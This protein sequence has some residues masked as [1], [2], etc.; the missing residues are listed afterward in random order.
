MPPEFHRRSAESVILISFALSGLS[1]LLAQTVWQRELSRL[2]GA[3]TPASALVFG[4]VMGGLAAGSLLGNSFANRWG[5]KVRLFALLEALTAVI[6]F[7]YVLALS[8]GALYSSSSATGFLGD[9]IVRR[10][11]AFGLVLM[12]SIVMGA[13]WPVIV[14]AAPTMTSRLYA[15]NLGGAFLGAIGGAFFLV[16]NFGLIWTL[17]AAG[18]LNLAAALGAYVISP[19]FQVRASESIQ[20]AETPENGEGHSDILDVDLPFFDCLVVFVSAVVMLSLEVLWTRLFTLVLGSSVYSV[21][22]VLAGCL[23]GLYTGATIVS[24]LSAKAKFSQHLLISVLLASAVLIALQA[25]FLNDLPFIFLEVSKQLL[26]FNVGQFELFL[27]SRILITFACVFIP[28]AVLGMSF[29]LVLARNSEDDDK[30]RKI[31]WL[32]SLSAIGS[33]VGSLCTGLILL[34]AFGVRFQSG[35]QA[36]FISLSIF[37]LA[38]VLMVILPL[39]YRQNEKV[40]TINRP[41]PVAYLVIFV[42]IFHGMPKPDIYLL[43]SGLGFVSAKEMVDAKL[44]LRQFIE[45][46]RFRF[47]IKFYREG[48]NTTV[49]VCENLDGNLR[50]LKNDGKVEASIPIDLS[51]PAPGSDYFTQTLLADLPYLVSQ[52]DNLKALVIGAGTGTTYSALSENLVGGKVTVA[53]IESYVLQAGKKFKNVNNEQNPAVEKLVCDARSHL[54]YDGIT[55]NLIVSQPAEPWVN[56]ASDL[57][58]KEFFSL[59]SERLTANG[60]FCQWLQLYSID[61]KHLSIILNTISSVF[62]STFIF[63]PHGAG[64]ILILSF[65]GHSAESKIDLAKFLKLFNDPAVFNRLQRNGI[66]S[67]ADFLSMLVL[68][69][70]SL[71]RFVWKTLGNDRTII[72]TDNNL[73]TEYALPLHLNEKEDRIEKNLSLLHSAQAEIAPAFSSLPE[74]ADA[75]AQLLDEI[76]YSMAKFSQLYPG[77]CLDDAAL[78]VA[79]EGWNVKNSA[80]TAQACDVISTMTGRIAASGVKKSTPP[81][82]QSVPESDA[83]TAKIA[84]S[85]Y[86]FWNAQKLMLQGS[87]VDA[88]NFLNASQ[89]NRFSGESRFSLLLGEALVRTGKFGQAVKA[90]SKAVSDPQTKNDALAW[91]AVAQYKD[92][93]FEASERSAKQVLAIRPDNYSVRFWLAKALFAAKKTDDALLEMQ[94]ASK[95]SPSRLSAKIWMCCAQILHGQE[96]LAAQNFS[97]LKIQGVKMSEVDLLKTY[98]SRQTPG[99]QAQLS[100]EDFK[101]QIESAVKAMEP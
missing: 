77:E 54:A 29:P 78:S 11:F 89:N 63:H 44:D 93:Q 64:E 23:A 47:P 35:I 14:A 48:V 17:S 66:S 10:S 37:I 84:G 42:M 99:S 19:H 94:W 40:D 12:P 56:G 13:T 70:Q 49:T 96:N 6:A 73:L 21:G 27:Y 45:Q 32:Y 2:I 100:N 57:Y 82:I 92:G 74:N 41:L 97:K 55:Y 59:V 31:S 34:T 26:A 88:V 30:Q 39:V 61:E 18:F 33:V 3:T 60:V 50:V 22:L 8:S 71:D 28:S 91:T 87:F 62:P 90:L 5:N 67:P 24:R 52:E 15:T 68:T 69:P 72:N 25:Y 65:Q 101:A 83:G 79:Y 85:D 58:T 7:V 9:E 75:K 51:K 81:S 86:A 38:T 46:E 20:P 53:E 43:S 98:F 16:P 80:S 1:A 36:M 76:A 4:G 95:A